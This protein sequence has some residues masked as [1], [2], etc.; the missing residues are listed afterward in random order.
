VSNSAQRPTKNEKR[1]HARE[2][3][4]IMREKQKAKDRR[5][6]FFIQGGI[7]LAVVAIIAI[8]A[9][10]VVQNNQNSVTAA[11]TA[12]GPLNMKSD[13]ILFHGVGGKAVAVKTAAVEAKAKPVATDTSKL[14][15]TANIVE[16]VDYQCPYC[17]EFVT[18]NLASEEKWVAAGKATLEIHPISILDASSE[19]NRYSSRAASAA[20]CVANYAPNDFL[21]VTKALYANQPAESTPGMSNSKLLSIIQGAGATGSKITG[22]VNGESFKTWVTESTARVTGG[23]FAGVATTPQAFGGTPTVFVNGAPYTG[24]LTDEATFAAFVDTQKAGTT[25]GS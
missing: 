22:C 9:I 6:R 8:V 24:S 20:A 15:S 13:G 2:Q 23:S 21:A 25:T 14:T 5:K 4:R 18:T 12:S 11:S 19:G 10:V 7:G 16:Y 1:D 3:A 17:L